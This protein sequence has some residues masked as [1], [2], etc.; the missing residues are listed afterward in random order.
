MLAR[1]EQK[2]RRAEH[3]L[4]GQVLGAATAVIQLLGPLAVKALLPIGL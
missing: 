3:G 2:L 4:G 1:V